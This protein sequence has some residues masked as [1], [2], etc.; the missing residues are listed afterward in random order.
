LQ[1]LCT[2]CQKPL[3]PRYDL[4]A[5]GKKLAK[6][7]LAGREKSL[8][9]FREVLPRPINTEPVTLGE[10]GTPL[11]FVHSE[12]PPQID[13]DFRRLG[14]QTISRRKRGTPNVDGVAPI[15]PDVAEE[16]AEDEADEDLGGERGAVPSAARDNGFVDSEGRPQIDADFRRLR[17]QTISRRKR[18]T[19]NVELTSGT[20]GKESVLICG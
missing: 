15:G 5:V 11:G 2:K 16:P 19:P 4:E 14:K 1:N 9:R 18:G 7:E 3:F 8:W 17:S 12:G 6:E 10:G 13:A 20:Q